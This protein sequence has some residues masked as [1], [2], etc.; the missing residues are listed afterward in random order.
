[1]SA[2][3]IIVLF[4]ARRL[5][6]FTVNIS[7]DEMNKNINNGSHSRVSTHF[8]FAIIHNYHIY[9]YIAI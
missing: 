9:I 3:L 8:Q 4:C 2:Y 7:A 6:D 1:M 5:E